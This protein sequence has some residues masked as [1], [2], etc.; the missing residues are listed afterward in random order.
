MRLMRRDERD[1]WPKDAPV[2]TFDI[3]DNGFEG[4]PSSTGQIQF[5]CPNGQHCSVLLGPVFV[6]RPAAGKSNI[7]GWDSNRERPTIAPSINCTAEGGG[8]GWHGHIT[9]GEIR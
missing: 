3:S 6:P 4:Y 8:C 5:V 2:G 9:N 7:W 1:E